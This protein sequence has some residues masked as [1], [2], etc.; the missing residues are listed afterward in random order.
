MT[1]QFTKTK[2]ASIANGVKILV[3][4]NAGLGKTSLC[5]TAPK[6]I[7]ISAESGLLS[8]RQSNIEKMFGV[9]T[10]GISYDIPV[11][12]I[13]KVEDLAEAY[14]W[15]FHNAKA[16]GFETV[17]LDSISEIA[18]VV[19]N[20]AKRQVKDPRAAYG[21][22]NEKLATTIRAFRDLPSLN[23][24]MTAKMAPAADD[25]GITKSGPSMPGK[26]MTKEIPYFFDEV[27]RL[28]MAKKEDGTFYRYLQ[29]APDL[30]YTAKDRSGTL[31]PAEH[32]HL[33]YLFN[34]IMGA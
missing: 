4:G 12:V 27:F 33:G 23:V 13:T 25:T 32:P 29:T 7:I 16:S 28:D 6:P 31:A 1:I 18:E 20:N 21:E 11:I 15:C 5:A 34:K 26:T 8:M 17:C 14:E 24:Y 2:E 22:L 10:P 30:L 9:E 19:L 3:Y